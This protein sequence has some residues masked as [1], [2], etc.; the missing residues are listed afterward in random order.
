M[1]LSEFVEV[2]KAYMIKHWPTEDAKDLF[3]SENRV[4]MMRELESYPPTQQARNH[5]V[6]LIY[7]SVVPLVI[8]LTHIVLACADFCGGGAQCCA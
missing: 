7:A 1:P 4:S 8:V 6:S 3:S 5:A 2:M